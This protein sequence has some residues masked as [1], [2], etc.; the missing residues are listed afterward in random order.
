MTDRFKSRFRI[1]TSRLNDWDYGWARAYF[2]TIVPSG[3]DPY[4]GEISKDEIHLTHIEKMV[5]FESKKH[6]N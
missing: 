3:R 6:P 4:W 2:V 1:D 5:E